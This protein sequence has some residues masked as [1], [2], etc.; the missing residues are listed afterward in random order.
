M[1]RL[2]LTMTHPALPRSHVA[3]LETASQRSR[4]YRSQSGLAF[5]LKYY[6]VLHSSEL[7]YETINKDK[8][9]P[10]EQKAQLIFVSGL[11]GLAGT[12]ST[13]AKNLH[14]IF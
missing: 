7:F 3:R 6:P 4:K 2:S 10:V 11:T 9:F 8:E 13:R 5:S 14:A 1:I 12:S